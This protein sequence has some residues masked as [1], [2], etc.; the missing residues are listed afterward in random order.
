MMFSG[1]W[2]R[3]LQEHFQRSCCRRFSS[4]PP[5]NTGQ[6]KNYTWLLVFPVATFGLGTWQVYRLEWKK[7]LIK[8]LER[9]TQKEAVP[10][11]PNNLLDDDKLKSMEY[12]RVT[13]SGH[14]D[15]SKELLLGP[16]SKNTQQPRSGSGGLIGHNVPA[17]G[18]HVVTPFVLDSGDRILINRGWVSKDCIEPSTRLQGQIETHTQVSGLVRKNERRPSFSPKVKEDSSYWHYCDVNSFSRILDTLPI[19]IDADSASTMPGGPIGGQTRVA[20]RN[21]HM[22]YIITW[23]SLTAATLALYYQLRKRPASMFKGPVVRE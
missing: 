13:M 22:Q 21:E 9:R 10:L 6:S 5:V 20:L 14:F 2:I 4:Q 16:R 12:C 19:L 18:Y 15:H 17:S 11:D 1:M 8:E 3:R 23:Y 7:G